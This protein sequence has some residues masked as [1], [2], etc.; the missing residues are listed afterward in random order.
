MRFTR[1]YLSGV[2]VRLRRGLRDILP[3]GSPQANRPLVPAI[4]TPAPTAAATTI[5]TPAPAAPTASVASSPATTASCFGARFV[6]DDATT[7]KVLTVERFNRAAS[8]LIIGY[9]NETKPA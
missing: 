2:C 9:F 3:A 1:R 4:P 8:F 5:A 6:Y 7:H